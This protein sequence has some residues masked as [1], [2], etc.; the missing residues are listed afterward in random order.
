MQFDK[1]KLNSILIDTVNKLPNS[2]EGTF[3]TILQSCSIILN[4]IPEFQIEDENKL[5]EYIKLLRN[6]V[7]EVRYHLASTKLSQKLKHL[8]E[9]NR[10]VLSEIDQNKNEIKEL[11]SMINREEASAEELR[12]E[13]ACLKNL[14]SFFDI[15][16]D[17]ADRKDWPECL[18]VMK[19]R[20]REVEK[21]Y[22]RLCEL[23]KSTREQLEEIKDILQKHYESETNKWKNQEQKIYQN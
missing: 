9:K 6:L 19:K 8:D 13:L 21:D 10:D 3:E 17:L 22:N 4:E 7:G 16:N 1:K 2:Q 12:E 14:K 18:D 15:K 20:F 23:E 11:R 5:A